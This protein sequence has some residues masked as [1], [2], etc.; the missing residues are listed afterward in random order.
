MLTV[1]VLWLVKYWSRCIGFKALCQIFCT[2]AMVPMPL[3]TPSTSFW[4]AA[5]ASYTITNRPGRRKRLC[6]SHVKWAKETVPGR[7]RW[8]SKCLVLV[9]V[10][11]EQV[12]AHERRIKKPKASHN[13]KCLG[14]ARMDLQAI[15]GPSTRPT[16]ETRFHWWGW[17]SQLPQLFCGESETDSMGCNP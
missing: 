1:Q 2:R 12:S 8:A 16:N 13:Y 6:D 9:L 11:L 5:G 3:R 14:F 7:D 17:T 4:A 15:H 10:T